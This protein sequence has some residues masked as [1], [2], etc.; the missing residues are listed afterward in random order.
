[1]GYLYLLM[2]VIISSAVLPASL[3]LLWSRQSWA[4]ATFSPIL[5]LAC[6]LIG[7]LVMA[8][9]E[10]GALTVDSTGANNPMLVGNV[11]ALLSPMVFIPILSLAFPSP[12]Y[13]WESMRA[14]RKGDD[15]DI[16]SEDDTTLEA[17]RDARSDEAERDRADEAHLD[18]SAKIARWLTAGMTVAFL[19]LWPM[20]MYGSSYVFSR[21]FFTGW[22][23][24]GI[25]WLFC[26]AACVGLYPLW[27]GRRT[28]SRTF[29]L[30]WL[31]VM[32]KWKPASANERVP[33]VMEGEEREKDGQRTPE[34]S[35]EMKVKM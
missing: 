2:G 29:R 10:S 8:K 16:A 32:G 34:E 9:H 7:W 26:S 15:H 30:M 5:G 28:S 4:A 22:V 12:A 3:T 25:I 33:V 35:V 1:M 24:V 20:P 13:N 23:V 11:V 6:S 21:E 18:R 27:E 14:I 31:D 19:V 17:V